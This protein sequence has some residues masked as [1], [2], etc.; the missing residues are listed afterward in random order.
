MIKYIILIFIVHAKKNCKQEQGYKITVQGESTLRIEPKIGQVSFAI[1]VQDLSPQVALDTA[2]VAANNAIQQFNQLLI[3]DKNA[4]VTTSNF[5]IEP[6]YDYSL[7]P[8][9]LTGYQITNSILV[10]TRLLDL[11]GDII[12]TGINAGLNRVDGIFYLNTEAEVENA[13]I[14]ATDLAI[15]QALN[16]A[17]KI[18]KSLGTTVKKI[19]GYREVQQY[20]N[21]GGPVPAV[22]TSS[23]EAKTRTTIQPGSQNVPLHV[24]V[25]I[26]LK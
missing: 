15:K 23:A 12:T 10:E 11:L 18:A 17:L 21:G 5:N 2:N 19:V 20:Y 26:L 16:R 22:A 8:Y 1:Q 25:D 24:E 13:R 7:Q 4:K 6:L 3:K 14:Q 9:R